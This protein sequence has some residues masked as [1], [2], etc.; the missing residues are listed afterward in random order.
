MVKDEIGYPPWFYIIDEV[1]SKIGSRSQPTEKVTQKI[2]E[3][4]HQVSRV[5]FNNRGIK[6]DAS[7]RELEKII[8]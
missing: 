6:T 8:K 1:C 2:M 4:G 7:I 5:H 3:A